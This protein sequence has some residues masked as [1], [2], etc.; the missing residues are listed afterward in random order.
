MEHGM[1][2]ARPRD[3]V[4]LPVPVPVPSM[5]YAEVEKVIQILEQNWRPKGVSR[6]NLSRDG[7]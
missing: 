6:E 7:V 3:V 1:G 5:P 2:R 4:L